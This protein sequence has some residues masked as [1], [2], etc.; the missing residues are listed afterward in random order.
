MS[1]VSL[2]DRLQRVRARIGRAAE[3]AG[4]S[5]SEVEILPV[6]KGHPPERIR[7]VARTDL[8]RVAE[9]RVGEAERKRAELG[10][11][12][13]AWHM[14]GHLQRNKARRAVALFDAVESVDSVRLARKLERELEKEGRESLDV[15][16]QV[17]CSG[18]E[19]KY[20]FPLE[21]AGEETGALDGVAEVS[22]RERLRVRG[23]MTMAPLTDDERVLRSTFRRLRELSERCARQL[24]DFEPDVLSMGMTNDYEI[25]VEE[26]STR[27]RLG[28]ALFGPR[29]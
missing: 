3:R 18:E 23:L 5:A 7:E 4:R 25:A 14:V 9:N 19:A 29:R 24:S 20:G 16:V 28:T 26:G 2:E 11:M 8:G 15:L 10:R 12:G 27:V 17:N 21:P 6:T 22:S 1:E 13:L